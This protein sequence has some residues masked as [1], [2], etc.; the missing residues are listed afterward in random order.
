MSDAGWPEVGYGPLEGRGRVEESRNPIENYAADG[1]FEI[2]SKLSGAE[3]DKAYANE[4]VKD[5]EKDAAEFQKEAISGKD[6]SEGICVQDAANVAIA[7]AASA[8]NAED[9]SGFHGKL[10][11][12][13]PLL[14]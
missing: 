10:E 8:G 2:L 11:S 5:H 6:P 4:I 1:R 9:G 3:F 14:V 12:G 7:L 13:Q